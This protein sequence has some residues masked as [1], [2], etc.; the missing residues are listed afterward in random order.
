MQKAHTKAAEHHE[1]AAKSHKTAAEHHGKNDH[2]KG[3]EHSTQA[4]KDTPA[5][6]GRF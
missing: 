3:K 6:R 4:L 1:L 2:A 5:A